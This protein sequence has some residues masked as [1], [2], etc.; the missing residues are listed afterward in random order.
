V[1]ADPLQTSAAATESQ[2]QTE[3]QQE[4][5]EE[6]PAAMAVDGSDG[7]EPAKVTIKVGADFAPPFAAV[8]AAATAAKAKAAGISHHPAV[9]PSR[10]LQQWARAL[11]GAGH[12][13]HAVAAPDNMSLQ[14]MFNMFNITCF[15]WVL[16][17]MQVMGT[18]KE[19][20]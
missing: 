8:A 16:L 4:G 9:V 15:V 18:C 19:I 14:V 2:S 13:S 17:A 7:E 1:E 10:S 3:L 6:A 11:S 12:A 20:V 5:A